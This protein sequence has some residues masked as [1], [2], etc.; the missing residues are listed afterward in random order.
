MQCPFLSETRVRY[1]QA[2]PVRKMLAAGQ[3]DPASERCSQP[4]HAACPV[5][6]SR[7]PVDDKGSV[8]PFFHDS[9]AHYC[10][11]APVMK[12]IP[13]SDQAG[14][15]GAAGYRFCELYLAFHRTAASR[16]GNMRV[17][18]ELYYSPN[19]LWL[20]L[21][22]NG[23]C[24]VGIDAFLASALE[25][26]SRVSFVTTGGVERPGAVLTA[27]GIDWPVTFPNPMR[28]TS[29]HLYLRSNPAPIVE[30]P[31]GTGWLFE[32]FQL[33]D[34]PATQGLMPGAQ[35]LAWME[36]ERARLDEAIHQIAGVRAGAGPALM[37]DGGS[38]AAGVLGQCDREEI[39]RV[40][41]AFFAPGRAWGEEWK[42]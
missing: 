31:Y 39:L 16:A 27:H 11:A 25:P 37:C 28:I 19:H 1:C 15:C 8:C 30:D 41:H 21:G 9:L 26:V 35:A 38:A 24:H 7:A 29:A 10:S 3:G 4:A 23:A 40:F 12:F 14:R 2:A 22:P 5:F 13:F 34:A 6:A 36:Q 17:P 32:G 20:E 18:A 42:Q 33:P